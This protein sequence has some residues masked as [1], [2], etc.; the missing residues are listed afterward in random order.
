MHC[1][2]MLVAKLYK[3][4]SCAIVH[5]LKKAQS[6][7]GSSRLPAENKMREMFLFKPGQ[8]RKQIG[9]KISKIM[10]AF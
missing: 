7:I 9:A 1:T 2:V 10:F 6:F 3:A 8:F 5:K 4:G